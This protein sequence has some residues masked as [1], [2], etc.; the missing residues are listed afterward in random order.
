[1]FVLDKSE[2]FQLNDTPFRLDIKLEPPHQTRRM[3]TF[4]GKTQQ[5]IYICMYH[6]NNNN[7]QTNNFRFIQVVQTINQSGYISKIKV[8][9]NQCLVE[10]GLQSVPG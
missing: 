8:G 5:R 6:D 4:Y 2:S 3:S 10:G 9:C 1:M 7:A